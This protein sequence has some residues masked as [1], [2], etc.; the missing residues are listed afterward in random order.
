MRNLSAF[1]VGC[2]FGAGLCI[3]GMTNPAKVLNFLDVAGPWDPTLLV[4]MGGALAAAFV[5]YGL[6]AHRARPLLAPDFSGPSAMTVDAR[7]VAG[8]VVFGVGW[9]LSG[10]C[11]GPA[12]ASLVTGSWNPVIF[13]VAMGFGMWLVRYLW[14]SFRWR[15]DYEPS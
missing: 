4:V 10:I 2:L 12:V 6:T 9:G 11:P 3:S 8:A 5:G 15:R 1:L 7:L 14:P 13:L